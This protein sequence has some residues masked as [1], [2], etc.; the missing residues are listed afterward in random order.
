MTKADR[1]LNRPRL[2]AEHPIRIVD[3]TEARQEVE[4]ARFA[5]ALLQTQ[6]EVRVG[7]M[8]TAKG[9]LT[10]AKKKLRACYEW[11]P[12]RAMEADLFEALIGEHKPRP[13]TSDE[14][15]NNETFPRACLLATDESGR[16]E[17][18]WEHIFKSVLSGPEQVQLCN[19]AI[20]V[21][22][23]TPDESLPKGW[24]QIEG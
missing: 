14:I 16:S 18:D 17:A 19:A 11:I 9:A 2:F 10:R 7:A 1:L 24:A 22:A 5:L 3:D 21:N 23:R 12:L 13:D 8:Q 4:Q 20:R 15:W 6:G